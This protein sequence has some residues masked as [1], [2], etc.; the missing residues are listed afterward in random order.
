MNQGWPVK[1]LAQLG[2]RITSGSRGWAK[3]YSDHGDLFVRITN[4]R[5]SSTQLD[6]RSTRFVQVDADD[7]EARRT[8]LRPGDILISI[9]ADIGIVG[10][11]DEALPNPAYIN[12]HIAR[13]RL[14][15]KVAD[16]R[17]IS[18]YLASWAPQRRFVGVTDQGAKAGMN[19]TAVAN[20][21]AAVPPVDE[22]R[23]IA[24]ALD[25]AVKQV[26]ALERLIAKKRDIKQGMMQGLLTGR[27][28]LAGFSEQ[29]SEAQ[30]GD[31][32]SLKGRIGWQGLTQDEFTSNPAEPFLITG[33]NFKDGAIRWDEVYH[34]SEDRFAVA[35]EI[36]L[37]P[38]DVL[39]TK[40]GTIGKLLFVNE[41]PYPG[42][43]TLNSHL[44]LFRPR[45]GAYDPRFLYYQ[46][47]SARFAA[48]ID[49]NKSG[50]TFFGISQTAVAKYAMVMPPL[51]EQRA[52]GQAL[53][54]IDADIN[55]LERR[56]ESAR[57]VKT[58]MMQELL[59][60]HTR[61]PVEAA[62]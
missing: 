7:A 47:G 40:D 20:L 37:R 11:V 24:D 39:M 44:L 6:L 17:F 8:R 2:A 15:P 48:H 55:A 28:R 35:P 53:S 5:R 12:Q 43:A 58:G 51:E 4:L 14:D 57:A 60:G 42:K 32:S 30:L 1:A 54:D 33:M 9:T 25:D 34:V 26:D 18:Y 19:L 36:Q 49:E 52:I 56:L 27:T 13:V 21:T 29:W 23:V 45:R 10:L 31:V 62:S 38:G 3:Y 16:S 50:T 46:L 59:T 22:Q 61:L 41:I